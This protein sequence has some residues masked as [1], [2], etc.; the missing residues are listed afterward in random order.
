MIRP[1]IVI[2]LLLSVS[3][4]LSACSSV[5]GAPPFKEEYYSEPDY[6]PTREIVTIKDASREIHYL[7]KENKRLKAK[8]KSL[9]PYKT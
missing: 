5:S 6:T 7:K 8:I 9:S 2:T 1:L 3:V 4:T